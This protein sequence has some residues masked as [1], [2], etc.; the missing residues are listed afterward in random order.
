MENIEE[1]ICI[2]LQPLLSYKFR[3]TKDWLNPHSDQNKVPQDLEDKLAGLH[4]SKVI[5]SGLGGGYFLESLFRE[6]KNKLDKSE[7]SWEDVKRF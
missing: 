5:F 3:E 1:H 7:K 4:F 2:G 6:Y